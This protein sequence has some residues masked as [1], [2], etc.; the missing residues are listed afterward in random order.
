[1]LNDPHV[2]SHKKNWQSFV[3]IRTIFYPLL[4]FW[5]LHYIELGT[6]L[7]KSLGALQVGICGVLI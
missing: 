2:E 5:K 4:I 3:N 1:M 6:I 7:K